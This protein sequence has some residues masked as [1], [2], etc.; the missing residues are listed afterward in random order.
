[1]SDAACSWTAT[2][3][4]GAGDTIVYL[5]S[6]NQQERHAHVT[7]LRFTFSQVDSNGSGGGLLR[8][9]IL[10]DTRLLAAFP[11]CTVVQPNDEMVSDNQLN[12]GVRAGIC[13]RL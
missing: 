11:N 13:T 2:T 10:V 9:Y 8:K 12:L 6:P 5:R 1:M 3:N 4:P 7:M